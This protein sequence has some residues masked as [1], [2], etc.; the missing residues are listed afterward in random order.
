MDLYLLS[1]LKNVNYH[2]D[3]KHPHLFKP[4]YPFLNEYYGNK[5]WVIFANLYFDLI[6]HSLI[7]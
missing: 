4:H 3:N 2:L 7:D 1:F 5:Y 6:F